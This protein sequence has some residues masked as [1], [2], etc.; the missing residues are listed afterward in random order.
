ML[1]DLPCKTLFPPR[2]SKR[3][4]RNILISTL[5]KKK[6]TLQTLEDRLSRAHRPWKL[7][8]KGDTS[9][10]LIDSFVINA[11]IRLK[12]TSLVISSWNSCNCIGC[13]FCIVNS[14][15]FKICTNNVFC[16]SLRSLQFF[17]SISRTFWKMCYFPLFI[18]L[19]V[20][21]WRNNYVIQMHFANRSEA[22]NCVKGQ[23]RPFLFSLDFSSF[24]IFNVVRVFFFPGVH[25]QYGKNYFK[26]FW[27]G[28]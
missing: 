8:Y 4:S 25:G 12:F 11:D 27:F 26:V 24:D 2:C 13:M 18:W 5:I 10:V 28:R 1:N 7:A 22:N 20:F 19:L 17:A 23:Q 3:R 15:F 9:W 6:T 16:S 14:S 21:A